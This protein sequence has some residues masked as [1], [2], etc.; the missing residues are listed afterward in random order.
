MTHST[1]TSTMPTKSPHQRIHLQQD[2]TRQCLFATS[3]TSWRQRTASQHLTQCARTMSTS[4]QRTIHK[5]LPKYYSSNVSMTKRLQHW[6][7]TRTPPNNSSSTRSISSRVA[8]C[9]NATSKIG[10]ASP[11]GTRH[12][13]ICGRSSKRRTRDVSHQGQSRQRKADLHKTTDSQVFDSNNDTAETIAGTINS[14]MANLTAQTAATI[15]KH[16][17]Q[18]NASLQQLAANT[19]QLH[20]QQ[21]AMMNQMAMMA[22][23]KV[24]KQVQRNTLLHNPPHKCTSPQH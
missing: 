18:T 8:D 7:R 16:A 13:S 5:T 10:N 12:G 17:T 22:M 9:T 21:Q 6:P 24:R 3:S 14:H 4:W 1:S 11:S 15:N 23:N 20:H 2:G 19:T